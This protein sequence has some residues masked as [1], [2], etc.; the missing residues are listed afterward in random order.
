MRWEYKESLLV[1]LPLLTI[2]A[3]QSGGKMFEKIFMKYK[4]ETAV[5][6]IRGPL[7][8]LCFLEV[9]TFSVKNGTAVK[10]RLQ[11][12]LFACLLPDSF[13]VSTMT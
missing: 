11:F 9:I 12:D 10:V 6:K 13:C 3:G 2:F 8:V 7:N 5:I 4:T 1:I